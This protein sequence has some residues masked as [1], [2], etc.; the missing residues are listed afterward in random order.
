MK[1]LEGKYVLITGSTSGIGL[2]IAE[3]LAKTGRNGHFQCVLVSQALLPACKERRCAREALPPVV[4]TG[5]R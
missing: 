4:L 1:N 5:V 3:E 2:G